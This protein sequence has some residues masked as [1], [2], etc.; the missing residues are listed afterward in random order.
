VEE[1]DGIE[2]LIK[3][4]PEE[5]IL[6]EE[7]PEEIGVPVM[8]EISSEIDEI[9]DMSLDSLDISDDLG[10]D[11]SDTKEMV[12]DIEDEITDFSDTDIDD[13][14]EETEMMPEE[15]IEEG[16]DLEEIEVPKKPEK[17]SPM[18]KIVM[19]EPS[20]TE[21]DFSFEEAM[22]FLKDG[23]DEFSILDD[24]NL[25]EDFAMED[26]SEDISIE[27]APE[28]IPE[29]EE[30]IPPEEE[31]EVP[32]EDSFEMEVPDEEDEVVV[33]PESSEEASM[34]SV[35]EL[36]GQEILE[37]IISEGILG[38]NIDDLKNSLSS[39]SEMDGVLETVIASN[40]G[41]VICHTGED[42]RRASILAAISV[43][44]SRR[45]N[46]AV[47]DLNIT[48]P[49]GILVEAT[50]GKIMSL[51]SSDFVLS[52]L[53][54]EQNLDDEDKINEFMGELLVKFEEDK[55]NNEIVLKNLLEFLNETDNLNGTIIGTGEGLVVMSSLKESMPSEKWMAYLFYIYQAAESAVSRLGL[56]DTERYIFKTRI[57]EE[58]EN[59]ICL[60]KGDFI[61][62]GMA[63]E[64]S[65]T[66]GIVLD[67]KAVVQSIN[68]LLDI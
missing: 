51:I 9:P 44:F 55:E 7:E 6:P 20:I 1:E 52:T 64:S 11:I 18:K 66:G 48:K 61:L 54:S 4:E 24:I 5:D 10:E 27:E 62:A 19:E 63:G 2:E 36:I 37:N 49:A 3:I 41:L 33:E 25:D 17:A 65:P 47:E 14:P 42:T 43:E 38:R 21:D 16:D 68:T 53:I 28:E 29:E 60:K 50:E 67:L 46:R 57:D 23:L 35:R 56:G 15:E 58:E 34:D 12:V 8:S 26:I 30:E 32:P 59:L 13:V 45:I 39:I 22:D 40:E 31:E